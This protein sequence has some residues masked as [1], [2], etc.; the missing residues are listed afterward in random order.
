MNKKY[1]YA[2]SQQNFNPMIEERIG[3][4]EGTGMGPVGANPLHPIKDTQGAIYCAE[5]GAWCSN[6]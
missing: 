5:M 1:R 2:R 6:I 4:P 3:A